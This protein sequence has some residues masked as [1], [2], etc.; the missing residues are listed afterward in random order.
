[1]NRRTF[2]QMDDSELRA[3]VLAHRSDEQALHALIQRLDARPGEVYPADDFSAL[4]KILK[5]E[6]P[7]SEKK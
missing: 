7:G 3:Y 6:Q 4:E 1:M 5:D 2:Q